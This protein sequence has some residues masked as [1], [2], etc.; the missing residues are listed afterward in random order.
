MSYYADVI[1]PL[2]IENLLTYSLSEEMR[3]QC[4]IGSRVAV[5]LGKKKLYTAVV[6]NIHQNQPLH[7]EAKPV[8]EVLDHYP[9]LSINQLK[10]FKWVKKYYLSSF[11]LILKACL[12]NAL[13]IQSETLL[14]LNDKISYKKQN[15]SDDE[16]LLLEAV[17][18]HTQIKMSDAQKILGKTSGLKVANKLI[19]RD[20]ISIDRHIRRKYKP[21]LKTYIRINKTYETTENLKTLLNNLGRAHK[22]KEVV[23]HYFKLMG[24]STKPLSKQNFKSQIDASDSVLNSLIDKGVFEEFS[25]QQDRIKNSKITTANHFSLSTSQREVFETIKSHFNSDDVVLF[26]GVTSS[27]KTEIYLKL[28]KEYLEKQQQILYLLPEIAL[29]TQLIQRIKSQFADKVFV[30]HSKYSANERVEIYRHVLNADSGQIIVGTRSSIFLPFKNLKLVIVD[31]SHENSYKQYDPSPRYHARDT[32]VVLASIHRAKVLMGSATPSLESFYNV[33]EGKFKYVELN[34]RFGDVKPPVIKTIDLKDKYKRKKMK[35]HFS[36]T[37]VERITETLSKGKQ[38]IVFQNRRG[39][40]PIIE[41]LTCGHSPQ[42]PHC[43]VSLT[44]HKTNNTLRCHYCGYR[45][46]VQNKCLSCGSQDLSSMGFG[47]EQ[48]EHEAKDL[49]PKANVKRMDL[50]TT[51]GKYDFENLIAGFEN[52]EIDILIGTQMLTKGL[53]FRNVDLV[54]VMHADGLFNFPNFRAF[55]K[56]YQLLTQVA[57][58]AGRTKTQG[59]VLIQTFQ[60]QHRVIQDVITENYTN[61][62]EQEMAQRLH[63]HYPPYYRII[64]LV[65]KSKDYNRLNEAADWMGIY[66]KQIFSKNILGPEFPGIARIRNQ[67]IKHIIIKIPPEQSITKTKSYLIK[68]IERYK[69]VSKFKSVRLNIDVDPYT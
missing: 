59:E 1:L 19:S 43:D 53:D 23:L 58:R 55:E 52:L 65:F 12:P 49:F 26:K 15:L 31:E 42:C 34:K 68:G 2:N 66:L 50:D 32:A 22:Q 36:D 39:Y 16:Y 5:P 24:K 9:I 67:Y 20:L 3:H 44:L 54:A 46:A 10:L 28:I 21:K 64:K 47:T 62:Y 41:C 38:I 56:S 4:Q 40:S 14:Q 6:V 27:G 29:T 51:R 61:L 13:L 17:E 63:F 11:G 18:K 7:Y 37:L 30:Y 57:G 8:K 25:I 48:I 60:P 33:K 69:A 35:G 45:M